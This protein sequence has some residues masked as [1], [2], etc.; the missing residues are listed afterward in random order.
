MTCRR[1]EEWI[2]LAI[3]GD[4]DAADQ[5]A[6]AAHLHG[7]L[8]CFRQFQSY[9]SAFAALDPL[10]AP[11]SAEAP[12]GLHDAIMLAVRSGEA[13]PIA[14]YPA[15]IGELRHRPVLDLL[16]RVLP[17]AAALLFFTWV[18]YQMVGSGPVGPHVTPQRNQP[19]MPVMWPGQNNVR[20]VADEF[21]MHFWF[22]VHG[23]GAEIPGV[24]PPTMRKAEDIPAARR[25]ADKSGDY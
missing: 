19:T 7:C 2:P 24:T 3:G 4:L 18:G 11:A 1:C 9:R 5:Q 12:A 13:G 8:N 21:G 15:R 25:S 22:P 23:P 6:F 17:T 20:P 14:P 16:R 10:R